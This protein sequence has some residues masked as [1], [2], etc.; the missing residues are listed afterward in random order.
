MQRAFLLFGGFASGKFPGF[1]RYLAASELAVLVIDVR[2]PVSDAQLEARRTG[3]S[4]TLARIDDHRYVD[5]A[6]PGEALAAVTTWQTRYRIAG[7]HTIREM[8]VET[9]QVVADYLGLPSPGWRASRVCRDKSLQR[10]HLGGWSPRFV[11]GKRADL[12]GRADGLPCVLK[13]ARREGSSGVVVVHDAAELRDAL[14]GYPEDEVLLLEQY[15][16]GPE[17]SI[18]A[19]VQGG[20]VVAAG[21]TGKRTNHGATGHFV[22]TGHTVPAQDL[23][24]AQEERLLAINAQVLARLEFADGIA[25]AEYKLDRDGTPYLMEIAA[26]N[27]GDGILQLYGMATGCA[28]EPEIIK[29][30][31][32]EPARYPA[33]RRIARQVYLGGAAGRFREVTSAGSGPAPYLFRAS[34]DKP[35][36]ALPGAADPPALREVMVERSPGEVLGAVTSSADRVGCFFLDAA[37]AAELD[38][39][40]SRVEREL[41][42]V[43]DPL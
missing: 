26:R 11:V 4:R 23:G 20:V 30:A 32:G 9:T 1:V 34:F 35:E 17:Y 13:P 29:I 41:A 14:A 22:E 43:V 42:V 2:T 27:P 24:A 40:E 12:E 39:L 3:A 33:P 18:E 5:P 6:A 19:L 16:V 37:T 36:L 28:I 15:V 38:A 31:L 25:H 10:H 7:V 21:I 8:F